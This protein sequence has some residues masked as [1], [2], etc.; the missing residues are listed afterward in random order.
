MAA[1]AQPLNP[2]ER[3]AMIRIHLF[4]LL[5]ALLCAAAGVHATTVGELHR[6]TTTPT[7][8][9]RDAKHS[10]ELRVT[11]WYP[12]AGGA[13]ETPLLVG[14]PDRPLFDAGRAA[15]D[16]GFAPGRHPV[17]LLSHGFGGSAR[18]MAWFGTALARAGD[19]VIAVDHPGNNG[20]D[21]MTLAGGLL[22]WERAV[23]L[24]AALDAARRDPRIGPHLDLDRLGVA[25]FSL[26]GFTALL[27]AGG[28][29]DID[30]FLRFCRENPHDATCMP[31]AEAPDQTMAAR[32]AALKKPEFA[33]QAKLAGDDYSIPGVKALFLMA[34]G[35]I[36]AITP[37]SLR[38]LKTPTT[39]VLGDAD[40]V[41][42]PSSNGVLAAQLLPN[43]TLR[44]LHD[45][46][47]YDFLADCTAAGRQ[48]VPPC[49]HLDVPQQR[50]HATAIAL[51]NAFFAASWQSAAA[52]KVVS[53]AQRRP[54][55]AH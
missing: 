36:E 6:T 29:A 49:E 8:A 35:A 51:A 18:I 3:T 52:G 16:A 14:P 9:I 54:A 28:R 42:P 55:T 38:A 47:H 5:A 17:V 23:D 2:E 32:I 46:G 33:A 27:T 53:D 25:G 20:R 10:D 1:F 19:V 26:G 43:A 37:A 44:K 21:P 30:R 24:K 13:V 31:Q 39:I 34:P 48:Q 15:A 4:P 11:V 7:A 22:V 45:V 12:A 50:T 40:P 41:A